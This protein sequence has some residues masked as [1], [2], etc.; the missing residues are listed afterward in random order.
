M[1]LNSWPM[2]WDTV[3]R[4]CRYDP[5]M[6]VTDASIAGGKIHALIQQWEIVAVSIASHSSLK[7]SDMSCRWAAA[8]S[9]TPRTRRGAAARLRRGSR[10]AAT[11]S[12]THTLGSAGA[13][14]AGSPVT[15]GGLQVASS[16]PLGTTAG[17]E[18]SSSPTCTPGAVTVGAPPGVIAVGSADG[19]ADTPVCRNR[20]T[21]VDPAL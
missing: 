18:L 13:G 3:R 4:E 1:S 16:V 10:E 9:R 6:A 21:R 14:S 17:E 2:S 12:S 5:S 19:R 8:P 15:T 7:F 20:F 11:G